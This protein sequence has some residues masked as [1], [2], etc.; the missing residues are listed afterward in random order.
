MA[1]KPS[2]SAAAIEADTPL[3]PLLARRATAANGV[4]IYTT[5]FRV[6]THWVLDEH[7]LVG[8]AVIP[9]TAFIEMVRAALAER[10]RGRVIEIR[11]L[12]FLAPL[13]VRNDQA[14]DVRL[15][16]SPA[17]DGFDFAVESD[18]SG[19]D[20]SS[21]GAQRFASGSVGLVEIDPPPPIDIDAVMARCR[22]RE[23]PRDEDRE[24]DLG[25]RWQNVVASHVGDAE[26][27]VR[28]ELAADFASDVETFRYHPALMDR[29]TGRAQEHLTDGSFLPI[30]YRRLRIHNP[31]PSAIFSHARLRRDVDP[32]E[33]TLT[34]DTRV[35]DAAG[36]TLVEVEGFMQRRIN[37]PGAAIKAFTTTQAAPPAPSR[38]PAPPGMSA[39][40]GLETLERILA[41]RIAPQ[42]VVAPHDLAVDRAQA[43][44]AVQTQALDAA[45]RIGVRHVERH[46]RPVLDTEY[47]EARTGVERLLTSAWED[48]LGLE[49]AGVDDN[50]FALGGDSVQAIQIIARLAQ[51]GVRLS[52]QLFFQ[53]QTIAEI[54]GALERAPREAVVEAAPA[55]TAGKDYALA[56]LDEEG[57]A[58]L[59][60]LIDEADE[61]FDGPR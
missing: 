45:G 15:V 58:Q 26:V 44:R 9:G 59:S 28:L 46:P 57:L 5:R 13:R 2:G 53:H 17:G 12:F 11:D 20:G 41:S 7:R 60:A 52:P 24:E 56:G 43:A 14:R 38:P 21:S 16:L 22:R 47:R 40:E 10:A 3:H 42:V 27:L 48:A 30:S 32:S 49:R 34:F 35:V 36:R 37:D 29:A 39:D 51:Q 6:D 8:T 19:Q 31:V 25:P 54:A 33:E 4:E 50:F 18:V 55:A 1:G 61:T 23:V